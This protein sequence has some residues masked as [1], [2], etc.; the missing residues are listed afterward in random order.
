M[1]SYLCLSM[2]FL[3]S[4]FH[5][6]SDGEE[7]EWPPSPLRLFQALVAATQSNGRDAD[8]DSDRIRVALRW[9]ERQ[10]PPEIVAPPVRDLQAFRLS[11]PNNAMDV[12]AKAWSRGNETSKD[13]KPSTHQAMKMVA[14][15]QLPEDS[16]VHFLWPLSNSPVSQELGHIELLT[17]AV[18][19]IVALGWGID[20]AVGHGRVLDDNAESQ[21]VGE[22]WSCVARPAKNRLRVPV[23]GTLEALQAQYQS[24]AQRIAEDGSF[25]A[26]PSFNAFEQANYARASDMPGRPFT[27][28]QLLHP[29][30]QRFRAFRLTQAAKVAAMLRHAVGRVAGDTQHT[31]VGIAPSQF[32]DQYIHGHGRTNDTQLGRFAYVPIPTIR[33]GDIVGDIRRVLIAEP[34][35]GL[36]QHAEWARRMISGQ[37]LVREPEPSSLDDSQPT[38]QRQEALLVP[39]SATDSVIIHYYTGSACEWASVTPV[40][41]PWGDDHKR[42][43]AEQQF[44]KALRHAGYSADGVDVELR[45]EPL[46]RGA[47][48]V[49]QYFVPQHLKQRG[50]AVYHARIRF[51]HNVTGPVLI[52]GGRFYGL[53]LFAKT[54]R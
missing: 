49:R 11:V 18:R 2:S 52:G 47:E 25:R 38:Q 44:F 10:P 14:G 35:D 31:E 53:G 37:T 15:K 7:T 46:W 51:P 16:T 29:E 19:Q 54:D 45:S 39:A 20:M 50:F 13:A 21:L 33:P 43:R 1:P 41:L 27:A 24:F 42:R 9:L 17:M 6:R 12:V 32:L 34:L 4:Q 28:F 5:G 23:A 36:G 30:E 26:V 8:R 48:H 3:D 40:V 22:R